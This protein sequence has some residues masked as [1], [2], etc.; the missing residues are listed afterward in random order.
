VEKRQAVMDAFDSYLTA[1][2][3]TDRTAFTRQIG[4]ILAMDEQIQA[5]LN[6]LKYAAKNKLGETIRRQ[7]AVAYQ[8]AQGHSAG[9]FMN[10][11][12]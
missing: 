7:Q 1:H 2:P 4:E 8:A 10:Y 5:S 3:D 11:A 9:T 6:Q 12:K